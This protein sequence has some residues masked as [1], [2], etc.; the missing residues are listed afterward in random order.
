MKPVKAAVLAAFMIFFCGEIAA[1]HVAQSVLACGDWWKIRIAESGVYRIQGSEISG[2]TGNAINDI[3]LYG[4]H[5]GMLDSQNGNARTDDLPELAI[6]VY[7]I[8]GNGTFDN[9]DYVLFYATGPDRWY[10]D[11]DYS[12]YQRSSHPYSKY[13]YI[14]ITANAGVHKRI[15]TTT[16]PTATASA[17]TTGRYRTYHDNDNT[18]THR[19]GQ[20]WVGERFGSGNSQQSFTLPLAAPPAGI[21][22]VRYALAS[23]STAPSSFTVSVNGQNASHSFVSSNPYGTFRKTLNSISNQTITVSI[24][25]NYSESMAAGY[26]DSIEVDAI[27]PLTLSGKMTQYATTVMD[28]AVHPIIV[29]GTGNQTRVWDVTNYADVAEMDVEHNGSTLTYNTLTESLKE[30][31]VFNSYKQVQSI[32]KI[33][34]QNIHGATNPDMVIVCHKTLLEQAQRLAALHSI[35]D[36]L[37]VLTVPQE[38]VFNEFSSGKCD[39]I[40]IREMLRM[41]KKRHDADSTKRRPRYLLLFGKA[42]YDNRDILGNGLPNVVTFQT[43]T[44]FDDDGISLSTDDIFTY[45]DD[46][47]A[48]SSS[49]SMDVAVGRLPAKSV[50]EAKHIV[51]KIERYMMKSDLGEDGIRGD[52]RNVVALL[53]DDADPSCPGDTVFTNSSEITAKQITE[54][55][56]YI[57]IDKIYADAFVQQSGAD[58][59]FYPDVNNAL[60]KRMDYGCL[61]LNYIGHGSSQYIGTE[62]YMMKSHISNYQNIDRLPFFITSTC[63]FG[64]YDDPAE[65]CGGEEFLLADGAGIA[66]L[67]ATRPISHVQAVN[68]EM[69]MQSLDP[70]NSI[71]DAIR[72]TKNSR[73]T[74]Q[75]LTLLGDP[76]LKLSHPTHRIVVTSINGTPVDSTV[77]DTALVLSTVTIEGEI[78]NTAGEVVADF[79]GDIYPEVYDRTKSA[80]TLA[81]DNDG[82][83]VT[84]LQQNSLLYRGHTSVNGGHFSY[85]FIVPRDVAYK[86]DRARLSHYA[87]N[88]SEDATGAYTNLFL[89]G[90]D[91]SADLHEVHP[92]LR[93]FLNDTNFRNGGITDNSP[94]LLAIV[95]DSIGINAVG[96]GLGHEMTAILDNNPNNIIILNDFYETDINDERLGRVSY[97]FSNLTRGKHTLDV[98]VWNIFNYSSSSSLVFYVHGADTVTTQFNASP[99]PATERAILRMEHNSKDNIANAR[100]AV[101]D[102][103]GRQVRVFDAVSCNG[104]VVGPVEWNLHDESG[105]RVTPGIYMA[106]FEATT[107][108]GDKITETGKIVVK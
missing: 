90:F 6:K 39:P 89:G 43:Y 20:I 59:S 17:I 84:F 2:L 5:G 87:K 61:I 44:S 36:N 78:R 3:G 95:F 103:Q 92:N 41:M 93:I 62:R 75:A 69:V 29:N 73:Y 85:R 51:D 24:N 14:Y 54:K 72:I 76:A 49:A 101:F 11:S 26:L 12:R 63:T 106:R 34:N 27:V 98:K 8:N 58:G 23:V 91:E 28:N 64:R 71:G 79:D 10:Y 99:N 19:S 21:V 9:E 100:L 1:Q 42:T 33:A 60:K 74:T 97:D 31:I 50:A 96:S 13:N 38:E 25:Y 45:L 104:Y 55:Y 32:E 94:T 105:T 52:W 22:N 46:G 107:I 65:T 47:E 81:N 18:N 67:A 7:D 35:N 80:Q 66:C 40:A 53:A 83:E 88:I 37:E 86:F 15:A 30:F 70:K 82:C 56:P 57:T 102:M 77:A 68:T 16:K 4:D 48:L 108:D